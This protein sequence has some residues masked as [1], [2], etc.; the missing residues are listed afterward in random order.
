V[1][2]PRRD[3]GASAI[4][5][6]LLIAGIVAVSLVTIFALVRVV[7]HSYADDCERVGRGD[8]ADAPKPCP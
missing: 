5:Y 6:A 8:I 3:S 7:G 1:T 4:E 2:L